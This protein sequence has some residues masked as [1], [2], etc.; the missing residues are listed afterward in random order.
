[1]PY[2]MISTQVQLERGPTTVGD[3]MS[4]LEIM[5]Y[6]GASLSKQLGNNF[7]E[8]KVA[9]PPRVVMNKLEKIGYKV[10]AMTGVGQTC[11][12]TMHRAVELGRI[13]PAPSLTSM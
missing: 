2:I 10:V 1:M 12:W 7:P 4:D 3:E 6:L 8:Y 9:D 11:I 13:W 5:Q